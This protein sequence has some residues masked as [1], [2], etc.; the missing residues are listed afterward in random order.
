MAVRQLLLTES[1]QQQQILWKVVAPLL[2]VILLVGAAFTIII[3]RS[4]SGAQP[5][6][7]TSITSA[8][9][10]STT[11]ATSAAQ[12]SPTGNAVP[13]NPAPTFQPPSCTLNLAGR[14]FD[15]GN[16]VA[17]VPITAK[18]CHTQGIATGQIRIEGSGAA[19][20]QHGSDCP[21]VLAAGESCSVA[22]SFIP[23]DPGTYIARVSS[24]PAQ[25]PR[26]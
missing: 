5:M 16:D 1:P 26:R 6:Q 18:P 12:G 17:S 19:A 22:V 14:K 13:G 11:T 21:P 4:D 23:K 24:F 25:G 9:A 10:L 2:L 3:T 8:P 7:P 15:V 20:F